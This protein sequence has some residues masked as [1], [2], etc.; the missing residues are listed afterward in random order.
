MNDKFDKVGEGH[1]KNHET[2]LVY[3]S[4]SSFK[5]EY[6]DYNESEYSNSEHQNQKD[7]YELGKLDY[8]ESI[9]IEFNKSSKYKDGLAYNEDGLFTFYKTKGYDFPW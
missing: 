3:F 1:Y 5:E 2:G 7:S 4:I 9:K 6:S 8:I